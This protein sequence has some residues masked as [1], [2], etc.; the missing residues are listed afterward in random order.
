MRRVIF[1][2]IAVVVSTFSLVIGMRA[3]KDP[4]LH[5]P[6]NVMQSDENRPAVPPVGDRQNGPDRYRPSPAQEAKFL[7]VFATPITFY[8]RVVDQYGVPIQEASVLFKANDKPW[9]DSTSFQRTSDADGNFSISDIQGMSLYVEVSKPGYYCV[10][11][12]GGKPSSNGGYD[13]GGPATTK[14]L[15]TPDSR[16]AV[17]FMLHKA[18]VMEKLVYQRERNP[19]VPKNGSPVKLPLDPSASDSPH[20]IE[21]QC[22]TNDTQR[23]AQNHY[24]WR[25]KVTVPSGGLVPRIGELAFE[26]PLDG[27][28]RS[29][30]YVMPKSPQGRQW[31]DSV[32]KSYFIRFD[33]GTYAR[34]NL[35]MIAHGAHFVV[36][37]SY[38]NPKPSSRNLEAAPGN[39]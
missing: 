12:V 20:F 11:P 34:V 35:E 22:W 29:D 33:D 4:S 1:I 2:G 39:P 19:G 14:G 7:A 24:D 21:V 30:E 5:S 6:E 8:G 38:L 23:D 9:A 31:E 26:A 36:F 15:H 28:Q 27:Y 3:C 18:G 10:D 13:Y 32:E 16:K 37:S 25:F 17:L